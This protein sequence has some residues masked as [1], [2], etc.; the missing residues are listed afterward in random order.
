MQALHDITAA[1]AAAQDAARAYADAHWRYQDD[2]D[3]TPYADAATA[4]CHAFAEAARVARAA[5]DTYA[6]R[7]ALYA[8]RARAAQQ[9]DIEP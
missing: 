2:R 4:A 5:A 6:A 1:D 7:S 3:P 9:K 8:S